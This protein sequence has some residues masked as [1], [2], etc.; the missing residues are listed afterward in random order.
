MMKYTNRDCEKLTKYAN[1][2]G[3]KGSFTITKG[4]YSCDSDRFCLNVVYNDRGDVD[5]ID[6]GSNPREAKRRVDNWIFDR[7]EIIKWT[8]FSK[9]ILTKSKLIV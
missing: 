1:D 9:I 2:N 3:V 4:Y 8:R 5:R 7:P 6:M